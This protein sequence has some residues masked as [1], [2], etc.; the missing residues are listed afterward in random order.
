MIA[1]K[2]LIWLLFV[3]SLRF[4]TQKRDFL[5]F[6]LSNSFENST[7]VNRHKKATLKPHQAFASDVLNNGQ[8]VYV[9]LTTIESRL[10]GLAPTISSII[11]GSIL[12]N[13]VYIFISK[14]P[15]LLDEGVSEDQVKSEF[16]EVDQLRQ[17]FP[18]ISVVF[19][20]NIGSHRKL[21]PLL[22]N[23]WKEDCVIITIDDHEIYPSTALAGLLQYYVA[24]GMNSVVALRSRRIALCSDGP[25]WRVAPYAKHRRGLWPVAPANSREHLLLPTGTG[26]VL[27]RPKFFNEKIFD[28]NLV[29][30]TRTGDDLMFRLMT[31]VNHVDVVTACTSETMKIE[32]ACPYRPSRKVTGGHRNENVSSFDAWVRVH[33]TVLSPRVDIASSSHS[34]LRGGGSFAHEDETDPRKKVSLAS[35]YNNIGGN[36]VMWKSAA[37][38]LKKLNIADVDK[39]VEDIAISERSECLNGIHGFFK[40]KSDRGC[41]IV[42]CSH[43]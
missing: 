4:T 23:K 36:D 29:N 13:H 25:P 21:L 8:R 18:Y 39:L 42:T 33:D 14:D 20:Q 16:Q 28:M 9:S 1:S 10:Y 3:L 32:E 7:S 19:T 41:A 34:I 31:L 11:D 38:Y 5:S 6:E 15:Y 26:G 17:R 35:K 43:A 2:A 30:L 27:Y 37:A 40:R 22:K 24:S 12:P